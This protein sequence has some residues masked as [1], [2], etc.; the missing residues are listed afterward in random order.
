[1]SL[2]AME[3][4]E[5]VVLVDEVGCESEVKIR[6]LIQLLVIMIM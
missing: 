6:K 2:E 4:D 5:I 1:M 3:I